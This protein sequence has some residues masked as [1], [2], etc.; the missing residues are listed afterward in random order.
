MPFVENVPF[1]SIMLSMAA[2]ILSAMLPRRAARAVT[3]ALA[4]AVLAL[5]VWLL[6]YLAASGD[7]CTYMMGHYPPPGATSCARERWRRWWRS[8]CPP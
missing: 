1:I 4:A 3:V 8:R 5:N 2:G 7:S 6:T